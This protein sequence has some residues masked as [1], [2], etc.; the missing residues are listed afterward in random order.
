M[1]IRFPRGTLVNTP[2]GVGLSLGYD[3][4]P[5]GWAV[6]VRLVDGRE[7]RGPEHLLAERSPLK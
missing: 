1:C 6:I 7:W 4:A 2:I 5:W 3:M